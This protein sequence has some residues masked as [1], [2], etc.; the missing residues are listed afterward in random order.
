[1]NNKILLGAGLLT[2]GAIAWAA[3][4][5]VVMT[6]AGVDVPKSEF[7]YLYHKNSQQQL[8]A[9]PLDEYVEMF[10]LYKLK[11]ADARA[12][13]ID[14]T[15]AFL[16]DLQQYRNDLAAPYLADSVY[17]NSLVKESYDRSLQ[18]VQANHI[19]IRKG[20][21]LK[22]NEAARARIDSIHSALLAGAD[23][24]ELAVRLSQDPSSASNKGHLPFTTAGRYP[25]SF[26]TVAYALKPGEISDVV[27]TPV[28]FHVLKGGETR[29][30]RGTVYVEH[31][32]KMVRPGA[33]ESA[34]ESVKAEIDSIHTLVT[35]NPDQFENLAR[36]LSDDV[37]SGRQG[38]RLPWFGAGQM[39]SEFENAAF[40]LADGEISEP[41][42]T[43]YGWH[44]IRKL[45]SKG[46]QTLEEMKPEVLER[47]NNPRDDRFMMVKR[48]QTKKLAKKH[49]TKFFDNA[50]QDIRAR[51]KES[52]L[53][54]L[55]YATYAPGTPG[56]NTVLLTVDGE[57]A[58][59]SGLAESLRNTI[60]ADPGVALPV[61][62]NRI[63]A[64]YNSTLVEAEQKQ[65]E[66]REPE[67]RNLLN[68]YR[69]GSLLYEASVRRVWDKAAKD[70]AGLTAYF[71]E[72]RSDY[73]W[74][75]PK[76]KG[77]LI[78]AK[79]DSVAT[80]VKNRYLQLGADTAIQTLRKEFR[81]EIIVDRVLASKGTNKMV[82]NLLF[83]GPEVPVSEPYTEYFMLSPRVLSAPEEMNDVRGQV[84][85]DYQ[86][87]LEK[88]WVEELK[89]LY[90]VVIYEKELKKIK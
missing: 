89:A 25:Y 51:V 38:G 36:K 24:E 48:E 8:G 46:P 33:P 1:M 18:E 63:D 45:A 52:G 35:I 80:L 17:I 90:P 5:P 13:G 74:N 70:E 9:Q 3:K 4:D 84:T 11:V 57:S 27:E 86:T 88:E 32:M 69:D 39:V 10:K 47:I 83:D 68:E 62:D 6:V 81:G 79:G 49:K 20:R 23:F 28:G 30:S 64:F 78:Q 40:S 77:I 59:A 54:S 67:Y 50:V 58:L 7:E 14:T 19:M 85:S 34:F 75:E 29:P 76:A 65:L 21:T 72:N 41:V 12:A 42:R 55:F 82:D 44:I 43:A 60:V 26:E 73:T 15:A 22:E 61:L 71:N 31:I 87:R 2:M 66:K 37:N 16:S 56:G 53:D